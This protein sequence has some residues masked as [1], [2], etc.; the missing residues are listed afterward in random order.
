MSA[1]AATPNT[2]SIWATGCRSG[3][4]AQQQAA[5]RFVVNEIFKKRRYDHPGFQ[6]EPTDTIVDIGA[7]MGIFVLWAA[8]QATARKSASHRADQRHRR[9]AIEHRAQSA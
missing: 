9:A 6:I 4:H 1:I 7:N 5:A 2:K 3:C 8:R